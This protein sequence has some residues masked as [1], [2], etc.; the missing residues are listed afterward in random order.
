MRKC[1][2]RFVVLLS[3]LL[4]LTIFYY[5]QT[6]SQIS[7]EDVI[8][9]KDELGIKDIS[10]NILEEALASKLEKNITLGD[11]VLLQIA[12]IRHWENII[13][14]VYSNKYSEYWTSRLI[15]DKKK[16]RNIWIESVKDGIIACIK[17][18]YIKVLGET[19]FP[20]FLY[21]DMF[22]KFCEG[23][24]ILIE[25]GMLIKLLNDT[26]LHYYLDSRITAGE[27]PEMGWYWAQESRRGNLSEEKC[28]E[29]YEIAKYYK[30][31]KR[32]IYSSLEKLIQSYLPKEPPKDI[33]FVT[34]KKQIE[35]KIIETIWKGTNNAVN[36]IFQFSIDPP[37]PK[38]KQKLLLV[39][40][41][42]ENENQTECACK[43][44]DDG[45]I[46]LNEKRTQKLFF[47]GRMVE[48]FS[49]IIG[50]LIENKKEIELIKDN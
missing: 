28:K 4:L 11:V 47:E 15:E 30:D 23:T 39:C 1:L 33:I 24:N 44:S 12:H 46:S 2:Y 45:L 14:G 21:I 8:Y 13:S 17:N 20:E 22:E 42:S 27:S 48:G 35:N 10:D 31:N 16:V 32:E 50:N 5:S 18:N 43:I 26:E 41:I 37:D 38:K 36:Y 9:I 25:L 3:T 40:Y 6:L 29:A 34:N 49:K 7:R 19:A